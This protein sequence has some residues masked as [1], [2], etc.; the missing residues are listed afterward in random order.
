MGEEKG[1]EEKE[2]LNLMM[3]KTMELAT[4]DQMNDTATAFSWIRN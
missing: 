1:E 2:T 3:K 4:A